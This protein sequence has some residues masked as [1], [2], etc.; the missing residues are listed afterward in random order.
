MTDQVFNSLPRRLPNSVSSL[1]AV[2]CFVFGGCATAPA[3]PD[4]LTV[5]AEPGRAVVIGWGNTAGEKA[6]AALI[7]TQGARVSSLFVA[8]ANQQKSGFGENIARLPPGDYALT[9]SC[10]LYIDYRIFPHDTVVQAALRANRVYRLRA[11]PQGRK[12]LPTLE[13]VTEKD[14]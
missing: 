14:K 9:V 13:D 12:C 7:T 4:T 1:C 8:S 5:A 6:R 10:D 2:A 3:N 11:N